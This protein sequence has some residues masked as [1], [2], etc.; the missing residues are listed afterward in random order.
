MLHTKTLTKLI[1]FAAI[2]LAAVIALTYYNSGSAIKKNNE[3]FLPN[4]LKHPDLISTL[5]IQD[6]NHTLTLKQNGDSW[7]IVER[8]NYPAEFEK[9]E[10]LLFALAAL[11]IVEPK[12]ANPEIYQQLDLNDIKEENSK[13]ILV[14][15][16]DN[17]QNTL[18]S[19]LI[20]KRE[21]LTLGD[22]YVERAFVRKPEESQ[23]WLVQGLL[24]I[25]NNIQDWVEQPL[26]DI[27]DAKQLKSLTIVKPGASDVLIA[28]ATPEQEDFVLETAERG[29]HI[30]VDAVNTL[31]FAVAELEFTDMQP[32]EQSTIDWQH[33]LQAVLQTF[34]GIKLDM[35]IVASGD[36]LF[37]K[38]QAEANVDASEDIKQ[39]VA[40]FNATKALWYYTLP[41]DFYKEMNVN[42]ASFIR[43]S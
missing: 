17:A 29:S 39:K 31:P 24:P 40:A 18:A 43:Q 41:H 3:V 4:L 33:S 15:I 23:T 14:S 19:V 35:H 42:N 26:L 34:S 16:Q 1:I 5:I 27:V 12:T 13:A 9:V 32:A 2:C 22:E 28:R 10:Q 37:A 25:S 7:Q 6:H 11:R 20:G 38:V 36:Q 30:D 21:G 8:N